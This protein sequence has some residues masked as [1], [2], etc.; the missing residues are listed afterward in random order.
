MDSK[1]NI[2]LKP[3]NTFGFEVRHRGL[4]TIHDEN[5]I[6]DCLKNQITPFKII[7]GGS[8]I[9]LTRDIDA[10]VLHNAIK[11]IQIVKEDDR[12][13]WVT[14]GGGELWHDF[15]L[16]SIDKNLGGLE[17]L[18][19]IPGSVGAAPMQNIGAYGV[20]QDACFEYL[21]AICLEDGEWTRFD[22]TACAFGYRESVFKSTLK[23]QFFITRVTY[24]LD[25]PPHQLHLSYGA[26]QDIL[27]S[28]N[29]TQ[30]TIHDVSD[31]VIQIRQSKLPDPKE[32][33]NAGS[34]FKNPVISKVLYQSLTNDFPALPH[35][36]VS[37]THVKVPAGWLIEH[38]H[39]KGKSY[40]HVGVHKNQ[41]L[42]IVHYGHGEGH[43]VLELAQQIQTRVRDT[44][45]IDIIPE[46]NIW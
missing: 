27:T 11:G 34:F 21:D 8:N 28:Q 20:E 17:N 1:N 40:K 7:G 30:P 19:L 18:S 43:E 14:I 44:F 23:D 39:F 37:D 42:V 12:H 26:I 6:K 38:C 45:G 31:A 35:Y 25:K 15:M 33:G 22:K 36:P 41:A 10:Y 29:I 32:L 5:D 3:F 16:W 24:R 2:S 46:V 13:V 4:I 9:L